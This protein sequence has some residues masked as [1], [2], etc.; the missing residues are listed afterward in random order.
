MAESDVA[1]ALPAQPSTPQQQLFSSVV[2][3]TKI[4]STGNEYPD[5]PTVR[6]IRS[7]GVTAS[8]IPAYGYCGPSERSFIWRI[9]IPAGKIA[10]GSDPSCVF[11]QNAAKCA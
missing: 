9:Q 5:R 8:G 7:K 11:C 4:L 3:M 1:S 2:F 6:L 10:F